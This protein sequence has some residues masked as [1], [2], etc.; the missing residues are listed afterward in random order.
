MARTRKHFKSKKY[1]SGKYKSKNAKK[2]RSKKY[3][4]REKKV[5]GDKKVKGG[6]VRVVLNHGIGNAELHQ[7]EKLDKHLGELLT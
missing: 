7:I 5:Q 1:K 4:E 3:S 2:F 6:V